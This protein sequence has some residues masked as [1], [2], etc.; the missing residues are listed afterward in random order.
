[1]E[2]EP[3]SISSGCVRYER[4]PGAV[5]SASSF[6]T[7]AGNAVC[8]NSTAS[9]DTVSNAACGKLTIDAAMH[10]HHH[11]LCLNGR[12]WPLARPSESFFRASRGQN[13]PKPACIDVEHGQKSICRSTSTFMRMQLALL[14]SIAGLANAT[15][16]IAQRAEENAVTVASDAFGTTIGS[17]II[18][19]YSSTDA[20]GFSPQQA[21]N[22]RIEGLYFDQQTTNMTACI[23]RETSMRIGIAAQ[24]YSFPSPTG[25][26]DLSLRTPGDSRA[27]SGIISRGPFDG[28]NI[29]LEQ[30]IPVIAD[31]LSV[32]VCAA[33]VQNINV[34]EYDRRD[35]TFAFGSTL[36]W[37]PSSKTEI[38]PFWSYVA[39]GDHEPLPGVYTD[40]TVP[41]PLFR[42]QN[43]GSQTW[44]SQAWRM[45]NLGVILK[46]A[47]GEHWQLIVGTF[48]SGERDP[49]SFDPYLEL[50]SNG[51]ASSYVDATPMQIAQSTSGEIRLQRSWTQGSHRHQV[52]IT[53]RGRS[54]ERTYGG[55]DDIYLGTTHLTNQIQVPEPLISFSPRSQ[56]DTR[57]VD[58]GMSYEELWSN[59]GSAAFGVL[60][61]SYVRTISSPGLMPQTTRDKPTLINLR[62]ALELHR[63]LVAYSSFTQGLEDSALAPVS[64]VNRG[65]PPSATRTSQVDG[66]IRY[67]PGKLQL[68]L[69]VFDIHKPYLNLDSND[70]YRP[71]GNLRTKGLENSLSYSN[72]GLTLLGGVVALRPTVERTALEFGATGS[73][74]LGPVPLTLTAN[75]D[76]APPDWG[77]WAASLQWSRL[78]SRYATNDNDV[79]LPALATLGAGVRYQWKIGAKSCTIRVDGSNLT[80]AQGLQLSNLGLVLPEL[81]RSV[82]LTLEA[83]L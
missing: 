64:A 59:I 54:P 58:F 40:G 67:A 25:I 37:R 12:T 20:R 60:R 62:L 31:K 72:S 41:L 52:L 83:D 26:A 61:S 46:S 69:G 73:E 11:P 19:L 49:L 14:L 55:D 10:L 56:D 34:E 43:L 33:Y 17:Q 75:V 2:P 77:P 63:D 79:R 82:A 27:F 70:V 68:I 28:L 23:V 4:T 80:N 6:L 32:D 38:I 39:G 53:T 13:R 22:I 51:M 42:E 81:G 30:Q 9:G 7:D 36:R 24:S 21:G 66:G 71:I 78:S 5:P 18:G 29:L 45:T 44:T 57:Q 15:R 3:R 74:P 16:A 65:E 76:Y 50:T 35:S 47:L 8:S 1:M 48:Y